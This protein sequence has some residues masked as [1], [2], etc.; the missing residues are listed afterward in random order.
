MVDDPLFEGNKYRLVNNSRKDPHLGLTISSFPNDPS[1][2]H[3][4]SP[5]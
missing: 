4:L 1:I 3:N 5:K 2:L